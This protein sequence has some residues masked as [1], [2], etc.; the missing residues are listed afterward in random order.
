[1]PA[2]YIVLLLLLAVAIPLIVLLYQANNKP[3]SIAAMCNNQLQKLVDSN[4]FST[5]QPGA[6]QQTKNELRNK[7]KRYPTVQQNV[8]YKEAE[9]TMNKK[10]LGKTSKMELSSDIISRI[11]FKGIQPPLEARYKF[12][13]TVLPK[14][15][16]SRYMIPIPE[17]KP[18]KVQSLPGKH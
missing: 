18:T 3:K 4:T 17:S 11:G 9:Q 1:M 14:T 5:A 7:S 16:R 13:E 8:F 15:K 12:M 10:A 2:V 6:S